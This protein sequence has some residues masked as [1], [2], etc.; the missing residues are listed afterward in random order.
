M[1]TLGLYRVAYEKKKKKKKKGKES[2]LLN[3][4][5]LILRNY[6]QLIVEYNKEIKEIMNLKKKTYL[7][8]WLVTFMPLCKSWNMEHMHRSWQILTNG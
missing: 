5:I 1:I 6:F 7:K 2:F 4:L 3:I 8:K